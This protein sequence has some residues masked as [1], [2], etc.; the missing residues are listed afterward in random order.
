MELL[1]TVKSY[2]IDNFLFGDESGL[3]NDTSFL[4]SGIIDSTGMLELINFLEEQFNITIT[5]EEVLPEN[6]DSLDKVASF[7]EK[8]TGM[9]K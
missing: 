2:I 5:D 9:Q 7:L 8:K 6:L 4:E 3:D 1:E